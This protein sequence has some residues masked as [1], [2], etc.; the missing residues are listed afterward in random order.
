VW[1]R[2][3]HKGKLL[4]IERFADLIVSIGLLPACFSVTRETLL[5][6]DGLFSPAGDPKS[7]RQGGCRISGCR[8]KRRRGQAE[9]SQSMRRRASTSK[10]IRSW[11]VFD[12][13]IRLAPPACRCAARTR[14]PDPTRVA[15]KS[16]ELR[17]TNWPMVESMAR[18]DLVGSS[19]DD[20]AGR[21]LITDLHNGIGCFRATNFCC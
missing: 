7:V 15:D 10:P 21:S 3:Q 2:R 20:Q 6:L 9:E 14:S 8:P 1:E 18:D 17:R 4:P 5:A 19:G 12:V 13:R 11:P 16:V